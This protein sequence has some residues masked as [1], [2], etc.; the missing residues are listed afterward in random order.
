MI[1]N[2]PDAEVEEAKE[3]PP[4]KR[5]KT[6]IVEV[7]SRDSQSIHIP[8]D[9]LFTGTSHDTTEDDHHYADIVDADHLRAQQ[10]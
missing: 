7:S 3:Q 4:L 2:S 6:S 10:P 9:V 8:N 5:S 1:N